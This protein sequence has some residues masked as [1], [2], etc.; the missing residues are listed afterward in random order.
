MNHHRVTLVG[1]E[2]TE[3]VL[4]QVDDRTWNGWVAA[5]MFDPL[6]VEA[7]FAQF[8][9]ERHG[10]RHSWTTSGHHGGSGE[11]V[12]RVTELHDDGYEMVASRTEVWPDEDGL[13]TVGA[14]GWCWDDHGLQP[15]DQPDTESS[16]SRQHW[17]ETGVYS[18]VREER[19]T[20]PMSHA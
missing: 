5:P 6:R 3:P 15:E 20:N 16:G 19:E 12:L 18:T 4:A 10:P 9:G 13:Y 17:I 14:D 11:W 8:A 7:L 1:L 2:A